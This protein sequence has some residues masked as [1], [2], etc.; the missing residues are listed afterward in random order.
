MKTKHREVKRRITK[1]N[2]ECNKKR[3]N[4]EKHYRKRRKRRQWKQ[5]EKK[6][7][8]M[9]R[10]D[11]NGWPATDVRIIA[12]TE[13]TT[14]NVNEEEKI[15]FLQRTRV[16]NKIAKIICLLQWSVEHLFCCWNQRKWESKEEICKT[17][18][19]NKDFDHE[20]EII[21]HHSCQRKEECFFVLKSSWVKREFQKICYTKFQG[22]K[23]V[24][25][26]RRHWLGFAPMSKFTQYNFHYKCNLVLHNAL[27]VIPSSFFFF[28]GGKRLLHHDRDKEWKHNFFEKKK[29]VKEDTKNKREEKKERKSDGRGRRRAKKETCEQRKWEKKKFSPK[30]KAKRKRRHWKKGIKLRRRC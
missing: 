30:K 22:Q 4:E 3:E 8:E 1:G 21:C 6:K 27:W 28:N 11:A 24:V 14:V 18:S 29:K 9:R 5:E 16:S 17:E 13:Q 10:L 2:K 15:V 23:K 19:T 7:Q 25:E 12:T 26:K 20:K